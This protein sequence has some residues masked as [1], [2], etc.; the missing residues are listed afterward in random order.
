MANPFKDKGKSTAESKFGNMGLPKGKAKHKDSADA[1]QVERIMGRASGGRLDKF[2]RGGRTK[3]TSVNVVIQQPQQQQP[4]AMPMPMA[5]PMPAPPPSAGPPPGPPSGA[6]PMPGGL[7]NP[8]GTPPVPPMGGMPPM[9]RKDGGRIGPK[10]ISGLEGNNSLRRWAK[11][12][13][14]NSYH[15]K[16][17]GRTYPLD[18]GG[19]ESGVGRLEKIGKDPQ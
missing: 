5:P 11:Y 13:R 16:D 7:L 3:P 6:P 17:G 2:A 4:Q 14:D 10:Y 19:A 1:E 15:R 9:M 18:S 12:A 8:T